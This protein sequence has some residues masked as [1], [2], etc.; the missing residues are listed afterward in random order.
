MKI[1]KY[2]ST[3]LIC[4][5]L[6]SCEREPDVSVLDNLPVFEIEG[7]ADGV[8][9]SLSGGV[10]GYYMFT[11]YGIDSEGIPFY[12]GEL[13]KANCNIACGERL[14]I[15]IHGQSILD[16]TGTNQELIDLAAA[17]YPFLETIQTGIT[18]YPV[19]ITANPSGTPPFTYSWELPFG[20]ASNEEEPVVTFFQS[21]T[22]EILLA[23]TDVLGCVSTMTKKIFVD[24]DNLLVCSV[25]LEFSQDSTGDETLTALGIGPGDFS[26]NWA[27]GVNNE[28]YIDISSLGVGSFCVEATS[29]FGCISEACFTIQGPG[30]FGGECFSNFIVQ[31]ELDGI[32]TPGETLGR[33][34]IEYEDA[35]GQ[36]Y[37]SINANQGQ[38]SI[39]SILSSINYQSNENQQS[40]RQ[41]QIDFTSDLVSNSGDSI[42]LNMNGSFGVA[43]E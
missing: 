12:T 41:L 14:K 38:E 24:V 18:G 30:S 15:T 22:H 10:D 28:S 29:S 42:Q 7:T 1:S 35:N 9:L 32:L 23:V 20:M 13:K 3:L 16:D 33:V 6:L 4:C 39:F 17:N 37:K 11:N 2:I 25:N 31:D 43:Y 26:Y 19:K 34:E 8:P 36:V 40:T 27:N 5:L 21:G